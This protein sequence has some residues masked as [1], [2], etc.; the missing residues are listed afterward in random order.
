MTAMKQEVKNRYLFSAYVLRNNYYDIVSQCILQ[1]G[2][3][4][5]Q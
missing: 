5:A 1:D 3:P 4:D 2:A